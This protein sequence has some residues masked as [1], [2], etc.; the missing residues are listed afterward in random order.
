MSGFRDHFSH[1]SA[2]YAAHRPAYPPEL[3]VW[4]AEQAPARAMAW[5]CATGSGQAALGLAAHFERVLATDASPQQVAHAVCHPR[6]EYRVATAEASGLPAAS[7]DLVTVAQAAHW[8]DLPR[9]SGEV[10]RV[11]RPGGLVALWGY[12]R[13]LVDARVDAVIERFYTER[14]AGC[15]PPERRHVETAYRDLDFPFTPCPTPGFTM[16]AVWDLTELLGYIG[17]WSA[18]QRY[19]ELRVADPMPGLRE[20][21]HKVWGSPG[22][23]KVIKW[24]LFMRLGRV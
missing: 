14:L 17:T 24:P 10:R 21:L 9:F 15:W 7:I 22:T 16:T 18:V 19:R 3:F 1:D 4:L 6:V 11:V 13:L 20:D 23:R 5:D 2:G 12:E 8:F